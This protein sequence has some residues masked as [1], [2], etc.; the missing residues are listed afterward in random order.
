MLLAM[1]KF[2]KFTTMW[3]KIDF[4]TYLF[5]IDALLIN[6]ITIKL[7]HSRHYIFAFDARLVFLE[8]A[9]AKLDLLMLTSLVLFLFKASLSDEVE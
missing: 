5:F 1:H 4:F 6:V 3:D 9:A 7:N 8:A 2:N